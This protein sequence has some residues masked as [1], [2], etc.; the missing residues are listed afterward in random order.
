MKKL[1]LLAFG[2][3]LCAVSFISEQPF[4]RIFF[5][6]IGGVCIGVFLAL[7]ERKKGE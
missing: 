3:I 4:Y 2:I 5:A 1:F 7:I 6:A